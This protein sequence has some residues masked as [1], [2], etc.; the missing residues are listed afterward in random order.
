M[1]PP[2]PPPPPPH[3]SNASG[4]RTGGLP[5]GKYDIFIIPPHSAGSGF[6]YL[7]S[8]HTH[9]N[10]FLA[11]AACTA[12]AFFIY[13]IAVPAVKEWLYTITSTGGP[14]V[15]MLMIGVGIACWAWGKTQSEWASASAASGSGGAGAAGGAFGAGQPGSSQPHGSTNTNGAPPPKTS[16]QRPNPQTTGSA[17]A[18]NSA[19]TSWEKAR[20]ETRKK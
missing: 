17:G 2:P 4:G 3:G 12:F 19:K 1:N 15:M 14:G 13:S 18:G 9:R 8:L 20:E 6:L 7:P 16:W 5:D 11:G 10:S